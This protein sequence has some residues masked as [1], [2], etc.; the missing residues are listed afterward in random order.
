MGRKQKRR[1]NK[2]L[3]KVETLIRT[4]QPSSLNGV[5]VFTL[6]EMAWKCYQK[7]GKG[8]AMY[9]QGF[10]FA[11]T[12]NSK[13]FSAEEMLIRNRYNPEQTFLASYPE[14][15]EKDIWRTLLIPY[16]SDQAKCRVLIPEDEEIDSYVENCL[17]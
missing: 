17:V 8:I 10:P 11:Y 16:L 4:K 9:A 5:K 14:N 12:V 2:G 7:H 3:K 13:H 1:N 15:F 6:G